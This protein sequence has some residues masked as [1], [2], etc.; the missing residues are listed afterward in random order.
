MRLTWARSE[1]RPNRTRWAAA[2]LNDDIYALTDAESYQIRDIWLYRHKVVGDHCHVVSIDTKEQDTLASVVN[3]THEM[4]CP[5]PEPEFGKAG[6]RRAGQSGVVTWVVGFAIDELLT[7]IST[8]TLHAMVIIHTT[9]F[10]SGGNIG[11]NGLAV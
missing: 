1:T 3:E 11:P 9:L 4:L 7:W 2:G 5:R 8:H 6:I 10:A